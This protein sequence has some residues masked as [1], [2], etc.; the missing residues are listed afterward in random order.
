[1]DIE[2]FLL[3]D[4]AT[5]THGKLNVLGAF[6]NIFVKQLPAKHATCAIA[7]RIRF[8]KS[9]QGEHKIKINV[10]NQDGEKIVP[11]LD[12]KIGV[13][14]PDHTESVAV[15]LVLNLH[16]L[17]FKSIGRY[18]IDLSMDDKHIASLPLNVRQHPQK[19]N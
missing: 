12:G 10:V 16:Q 6:D 8:T 1:M 7:A 13:R 3:C 15:N 11:T 9:E 5:D 17:E 19:Q 2:A 4:A 18:S 14:I